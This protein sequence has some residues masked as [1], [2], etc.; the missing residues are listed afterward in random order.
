MGKKN[1]ISIAADIAGKT[2]TLETGKLAA[3]ADGSVVL[4]QG[5]MMLLATVVS[6]KEAK[7]GQSFFPL[8]VDY[9]E[10]F[11]AA[12]RIPGSF[13][14][15]EGRP[16]GHEILV[17]RLIDRVIRPMFPDTYLNETQIFVY[18]IATDKD[19]TP[20][21]YA[22]LAASAAL[23]VSDIP[24][25]TPISEVRIARI[26]GEFVINPVRT[27]LEKADMNFMIGGTLDNIVMVEGEADECDEADLLEAI[28]IAH[29]TIKVQCQMQLDLRA[30]LDP[31]TTREVLVLDEDEDL[32]KEIDDLCTA[33][34][35]AVARSGSSKHE[36]FVGFDAVKTKMKETLLEKY[37]EEFMEEKKDMISRY[38]KKVHK[39]TIREMVMSD[40]IRLDGRKPDEIRNIWCEIDYLPT[41]HGSAI[42]TRGETQSLTTVT[43]GSKLDEQMIDNAEELHFDRFY[44][45]YNFTPFSTG[46]VKRPRGVSRREIGHGNLAR[47]S[48]EQ[49]FP[50]EYA[51]TV[52]IVSDILE[53]N[54]S[55]SM[56]TVCAGSLALM[57]AGV[58]IKEPVSGIAMGLISDGT[59]TVVLSDIL[60]DEDHL[61]DMDFKL[62]GT[63][64]GVC[65][66]Q[67]DI[68]IDGLDYA[69]LAEALEQ[70]KAGRMHILG[71]MN[72][73][74]ATSNEQ[75]K[76]HAPRIERFEI[77][78]D[79][80]GAVIGPG[81]KI[82]QQ[83]QAD[84]GTTITIEEKDGK[85]IVKISGVGGEGVEEAVATVKGIAMDPE[86]NTDYDAKVVKVMPYGAFVQFM[87]G[88]EGL[89]H[90]SEISW[91][92]IDKVEDVLKEGDD[93][94]VRL[95]GIDSRTGKFKL[96]RKVLIPRPEKK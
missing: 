32:K 78:S 29:E 5:N 81:G 7:E 76:P 95:V 14:R 62:T 63:K 43:L 48:L 50:E 21:A 77:N 13:H 87:P 67:M 70:A 52:R 47:R 15:R 84:T 45:H 72:D 24:F 74:I 80:I 4:R 96:S 68:K 64:N 34:I 91:A 75:L 35:D 66:C 25:L 53:S 40:K 33:G 55:S 57:D 38:Y 12:G 71:V 41:T 56:A 83:I 58:P 89:L 36:R 73:T 61:G 22:A 20:D 3:L 44:L 94:K 82:I 16:S 79:K 46:E 54:G 8:S 88:K 10:N 11:A 86:V 51:Y 92:R 18:L 28:K 85:G 49:V 60:G 31:I 30:K 90:V 65:A 23:M 93:V 2:M 59:R 69:L 42:F 19:Q 27:E 37:G 17:C 39:G 6:T 1:A 26:D 9:K